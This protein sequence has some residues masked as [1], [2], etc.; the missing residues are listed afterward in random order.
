MFSQV[1]TSSSCL[2]F[3]SRLPLYFSSVLWGLSC[4]WVSEAP[5]QFLAPP[6]PAVVQILEVN[7]LHVIYRIRPCQG[8]FGDGVS[9]CRGAGRAVSF[10][11]GFFLINSSMSPA[12]ADWPSSASPDI[13]Q[14]PLSPPETLHVVLLVPPLLVF[15]PSRWL[16]APPYLT[17]RR[18]V[19][20]A[21]PA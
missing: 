7:R 17:K 11:R 15:L 2:S 19:G 3:P 9:V 1:H 18:C 5:A 20:P 13:K 12:S 14:R 4:S 8:L 10:H 6:F 16:L 21:R